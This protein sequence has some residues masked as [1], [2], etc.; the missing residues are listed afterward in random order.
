[1]I[2][3]VS[4]LPT[5]L[6]AAGAA[7][8]L[9]SFGAGL[10]ARLSAPG[11]SWSLDPIG[12]AVPIFFAMIAAELWVAHRRGLAVYGV[13]D[14]I[15]CM[16]TGI[17]N[18]VSGVFVGGLAFALYAGLVERLAWVQLPADSAL[19][20]IACFVLVDFLYYWWHRASHRINVLWAVHVVHHQSEE[21]NLAVAL[22]QAL[23]SPVTYNPF[24]WGLAFFG[25]PPIVLFTCQALNTLY[26]F[27]I[28]TQLVGRLP[29][30]VE[31]VL[32]TPSHHRVHHGVNPRYIDRNH[33]GVFIVWDKLFGTFEAEREAPVFG[34]VKGLGRWDPLWANFDELASLW[35]RASGMPRW[36]D[37]LRLLVGP[38]EWRPASQGGPLSVPI[39]TP[40]QRPQPRAAVPRAVTAYVAL[41]FGPAAIALTLL[42]L[43]RPGPEATALWGGLL[44]LTTGSWGL[45]FDRRPA[46]RTVEL[47]R[48][49]AC[50]G[51]SV[52]LLLHGQGWALLAGMVLMA[53]SLMS[54][55]VVLRLG[56]SAAGPLDTR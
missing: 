54:A 5:P 52:L 46:A 40:G 9:A 44:L 36:S 32:N 51:F 3:L 21:Y 35:A 39:P 25:F 29:P 56:R 14:A 18:Q 24:F 48:L 33:A 19:T 43:V 42:L 38:P 41:W 8:L 28:H 16:A 55:P 45:L 27:W 26:Q 20:W 4:S 37:R 22:R 23:F 6:L 11:P 13:L 50:A 53:L 47:V 30:S 7:P 10:S 1:M 2:G 15:S 49:G 12:L 31:A 34:T 17:G